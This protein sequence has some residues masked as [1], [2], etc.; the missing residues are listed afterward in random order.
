M[1]DGTGRE[2][3]EREREGEGCRDRLAEEERVDPEEDLVLSD[4]EVF[5]GLL[6]IPL[7]FPFP[8]PFPLAYPLPIGY[9]LKATPES[10]R[11]PTGMIPTGKGGISDPV[12]AKNP[13]FVEEAYTLEEDE[14]KE[15]LNNAFVFGAEATRR[16]KRVADDPFCEEPE[17]VGLV[18]I[19]NVA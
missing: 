9:G 3:C 19:R 4:E 11:S 10:L 18:G 8:F 17:G 5:E 12:G 14:K 15:P 16:K 1:K 7:S 2:G 13:F 6:L